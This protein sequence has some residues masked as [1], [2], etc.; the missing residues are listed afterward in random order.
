[1]KRSTSR[2]KISD[3]VLMKLETDLN[4]ERQEEDKEKQVAK[5]GN[6]T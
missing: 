4:G 5:C 6:Q 2:D 1:M 3:D